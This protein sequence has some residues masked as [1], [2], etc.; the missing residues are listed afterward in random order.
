LIVVF[1]VDGYDTLITKAALY[2]A[3][4]LLKKPH[5]VM[6]V[7]HLW[8]QEAAVEVEVEVEGKEGEGRGQG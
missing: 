3:K 8:G 2:G 4:L 6:I 1:G 5:Q 7:N